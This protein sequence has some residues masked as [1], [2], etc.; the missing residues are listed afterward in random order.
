MEI[1]NTKVSALLKD[2]ARMVLEAIFNGQELNLK[3]NVVKSNIGVLLRKG[4]IIRGEKGYFLTS[5]VLTTVEKQLDIRAQLRAE[6]A[7]P[8]KVFRYDTVKG[9]TKVGWDIISGMSVV[10]D[11]VKLSRME[12]KRRMKYCGTLIISVKSKHMLQVEMAKKRGYRII[13]RNL[14]TALYL[15][16]IGFSVKSSKDGNLWYCDTLEQKF[17]LQ[18]LFFISQQD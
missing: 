8:N 18:G 1:I 13:A 14:D 3:S 2:N 5:D 15:K 12:I 9:T 16:S 7:D 4:L 17:V 10:F 6:K 11:Y